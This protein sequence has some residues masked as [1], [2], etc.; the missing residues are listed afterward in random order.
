MAGIS[1]AIATL[2]C[3]FS[4]SNSALATPGDA[5]P[6]EAGHFSSTGY[7]SVTESITCSLTPPGTYQDSSNATAPIACPAGT[8]QPNNGSISCIQSMPGTYAPVNSTAA[9]PCADG[10][11]ASAGQGACT[12]ASP[13]Y[14]ALGDKSMQ[15]MCIAGTYQSLSGQ[16]TCLMASAGSYVADSGSSTA[17]PCPLGAFQPNM[18]SISCGPAA[19]GTYVD[20]TGAVQATGC[21]A[22]FTTAATGSTSAADCN[23]STL[24]TI[25]TSPTPTA[26]PTPSAT[27]PPTPTVT[28]APVIAQKMV[29]NVTSLKIPKKLKVGSKFTFAKSVSKGLTSK[30]SASGACKISSGRTTFTVTAFRKTGTCNLTVSNGGSATYF[31]LKAKFALKVVR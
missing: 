13:G 17:T 2:L 16:I 3:V 9:L 15:V 29:Q 12:L 31:P 21:P 14:Y 18:G 10:S 8:F 27:E 6:C 25:L 30:A 5:I 11:Y 4:I 24:V 23:I 1:L 26:T 7:A 20:T 28:A 22:H 19:L